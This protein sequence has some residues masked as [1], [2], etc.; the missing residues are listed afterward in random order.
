MKQRL[1]NVLKWLLVA[2]GILF[3]IQLLI[4]I[5]VILG[6]KGFSNLDYSINKHSN[7]NLKPIQ[8][9]INYAQDYRL[10]HGKY[11][12]TIE[13]IRIKPD[14][15]FKYETSSNNAC[16]SVTTKSKK[17][18]LTRQYQRCSINSD[19]SNSSSESYVEYSN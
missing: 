16:F 6:I 9:I 14:L 1:M 2:F 10:K 15:Y 17:D 12:D 3:L 8:P 4:V 11:P 7:K 5:G 19:N 18:N 13:G